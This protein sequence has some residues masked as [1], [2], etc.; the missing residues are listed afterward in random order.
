MTRTPGRLFDDI[1]ADGDLAVLAD[2]APEIIHLMFDHLRTLPLI[3]ANAY[4]RGMAMQLLN[5]LGPHLS[6]QESDLCRSIAA[7]TDRQTLDAKHVEALH[8]A[9][10]N[11]ARRALVA[12][13][14][15]FIVTL[16]SANTVPA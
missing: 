7:W 16:A 3:E 4:C 5:E 14:A 11:A 13:R 6:K 9:C 15:G 2:L 10:R 8:H 12:E 1:S